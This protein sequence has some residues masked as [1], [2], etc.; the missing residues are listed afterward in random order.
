MC[1]VGANG[2]AGKEAKEEGKEHGPKNEI[3]EQPFH[4]QPLEFQQ[5]DE[6][7]RLVQDA[8][9][10]QREQLAECERQVAYAANVSAN[11]RQRAGR[12]D[13]REGR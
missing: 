3:L 4:P 2:A 1:T 7:E 9:L 12:E 11:Q 6:P 10:P 5:S 8:K 13:R